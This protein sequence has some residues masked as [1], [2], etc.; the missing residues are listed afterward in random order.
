MALTN[1]AFAPI[2]QGEDSVASSLGSRSTRLDSHGCWKAASTGGH[3]A[4]HRVR[5]AP[6]QTEPFWSVGCGLLIVDHMLKP[7]CCKPCC[8]ECSNMCAVL[9]K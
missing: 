6:V 5:K 2:L 4:S 8:T 3:H 1:P 7:S 9:Y